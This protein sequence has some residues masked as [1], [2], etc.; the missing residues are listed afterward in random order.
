VNRYVER[1]REKRER[2]RER[3]RAS[4][5]CGYYT[6]ENIPIYVER[7]REKKQYVERHTAE[8]LS[9]SLSLSLFIPV[10]MQSAGERRIGM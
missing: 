9:L 2:E 1:R 10:G 3:E 8:T 7:R 6:A 5:V 4:A